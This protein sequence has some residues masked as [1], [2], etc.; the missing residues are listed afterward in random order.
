MAFIPLSSDGLADG[1]L[2]HTLEFGTPSHRY[3][4]HLLF[5]AVYETL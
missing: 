2:R 4:G 5:E 3:I 1:D